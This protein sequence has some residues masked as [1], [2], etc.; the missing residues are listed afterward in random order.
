MAFRKLIKANET[1][2]AKASITKHCVEG[3]KEALKLKKKKG[4]R[5]K[6]LN[7]TGEPSG[8]A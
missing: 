5:G 6:K 7:L 1:N 2:A 8:K 3:L 4:Q